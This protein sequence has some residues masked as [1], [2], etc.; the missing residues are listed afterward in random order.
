MKTLP[1][2]PPPHL[3]CDAYPPPQGR[4]RITE[5][6]E[7]GRAWIPFGKVRTASTTLRGNL[8]DIA[9]DD[10]IRLLGARARTGI[11][12][13]NPQQPLRLVFADGAV[14]MG[15]SS[16]AMALGRHLLAAGSVTAQQLEDL[17]GLTQGRTGERQ[18]RPLDD[19]GVLQAM[20]TVVG[21]AELTNAVRLLAVGTVFEMMLLADAPLEFVE[22]PP[23]PL[24]AHFASDADAV[25]S[26]ARCQ[27]DAWPAMQAA[28]GAES[29]RFRRVQRVA[30]HHTPIVLDALSWAALCEI[31]ER[32]TAGQ[33]SHRLGLGRYPTAALL[34]DLTDRGLIER[35]S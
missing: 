7:M 3:F 1:L 33:I 35:V 14:V 13:V 28:G 17:F 12:V 2:S 24:A 25:V 4:V 9:I 21:R 15:G 6:V 18:T 32:A 23:H 29:A 10:V 27:A 22:A 19:I 11:L 26:E 5:R 30:S 31:D 20:L 34:A 8:A 16:S